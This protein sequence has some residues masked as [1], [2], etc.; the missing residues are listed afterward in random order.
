M[1]QQ[2]LIEAIALEVNHRQ[3]D[4]IGISSDKLLIP[5]SCNF[6][7]MNQSSGAENLLHTSMKIYF[8]YLI[9]K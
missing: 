6:T 7:N 3:W 9:Y 1:R 4:Q 5:C 2:F 8:N